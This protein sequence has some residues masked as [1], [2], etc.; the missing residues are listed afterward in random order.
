MKPLALILLL[1]LFA[2]AS[3]PKYPEPGPCVVTACG[4]ECCNNDGKRCPP[5]L[6]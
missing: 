5:C 6:P 3:A 4:Y 2:C 1:L